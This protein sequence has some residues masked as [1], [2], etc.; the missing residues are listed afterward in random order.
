MT[1]CTRHRLHYKHARR[2]ICLDLVP[3][4]NSASFIRSC[5]RFILRYGCPV[6]L[7]QITDQILFLTKVEILLLRYL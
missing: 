6:T 4:M 1:L 5:K 7:Y 2:A 3:N